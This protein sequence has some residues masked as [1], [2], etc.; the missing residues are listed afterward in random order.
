MLI[1]LTIILSIIIIT[2]TSDIKEEMPT[3]VYLQYCIVGTFFLYMILSW[4]L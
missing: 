4:I 3:F 2:I 1:L